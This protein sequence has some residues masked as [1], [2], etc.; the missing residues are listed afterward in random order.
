MPKSLF[1][2]LDET[3]RTRI[4]EAA[5]TEFSSNIYNESSINQ[6]IKTADISRGSF[7]KY[8]EDKE[9]VYFHMVQI[10]FENT[11]VTFF[12]THED[13][14][15]MS[16]LRLYRESFRY[17]L[18]LLSNPQYKSFIK[19][20]HLSMNYT[21]QQKYKIIFTGIRARMVGAF[22][23]LSMHADKMNNSGYLELMNMLELI[24]RDL[25]THK[26]AND[27]EDTEILALY[28]LRMRV[29]LNLESYI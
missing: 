20:M 21:F 24:N 22:S 17:H 28:D 4:T 2:K 16:I 25:I 5:L 3:K 11:A 1:F 26:I 18:S 12:D 13:L 15:S 14:E 29:L 7:Y 27:L 6:I 19:N 9:D 8:F 23:R 10:V